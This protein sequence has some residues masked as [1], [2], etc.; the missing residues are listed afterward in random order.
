MGGA[1]FVHIAAHCLID[2]AQPW[3]SALFLSPERGV[4]QAILQL[5][6]ESVYD[7]RITA[8][9]IA[10]TWRCPADV[11]VFSGCRTALGRDAG[12]EGFLGFSQAA[13]VS[14]A[15]SVVLT[16]WEVE[17]VAASMLMIRFYEN[18]LGRYRDTRL[19][20]QV[21]TPMPKAE[22]LF[23]AKQRLRSLTLDQAIE[24]SE[25]FGEFTD[26]REEWV[27]RKK[28]QGGTFQPFEHPVYWAGFVLIGDDGPVEIQTPRHQ[29][30]Q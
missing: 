21:G 30:P 24:W 8:G 16:L 11:L 13:L 10:R 6:D 9:Q 5:T 7:G 22:A 15:R 14:G 27:Q 4:P 20:F 18:L 3:E 25:Q 29:S 1:R 26:L 17:D 19:G 12:G 2:D 28:R 23:E